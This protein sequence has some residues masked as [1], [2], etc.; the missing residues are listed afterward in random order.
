MDPTEDPKILSLRLRFP[1]LVNK[2]L[3]LLRSDL[4]LL[5]KLPKLGDRA[6]FCETKELVAD[7]G[8]PAGVVETS[9]K[10]LRLLSGVEGELDPKGS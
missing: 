9:V 1:D 10:K 7:G 2:E 3:E 8:G 5:S 6:G 4:V